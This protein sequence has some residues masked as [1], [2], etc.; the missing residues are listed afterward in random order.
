M[1]YLKKIEIVDKHIESGEWEK[2]NKLLENLAQEIPENGKVLY[3][4][5]LL[6]QQ[7]GEFDL[8]LRRYNEAMEKDPGNFFVYMNIALIKKLSGDNREEEKYLNEALE[9]AKCKEERWFAL[10]SLCTHYMNLHTYLK[11]EKFAKQIIREFED[12]YE[13]YHLY[14]EIQMRRKSYDEAISYIEEVPETMKNHPQYLADMISW[15]ERSEQ[16]EKLLDLLKNDE[17]IKKVIP[18]Y[19][20]RKRIAVSGSLGHTEE[21]IKDLF[22]MLKE[23]KDVDAAICLAFFL[24]LNGDYEQSADLAN[25]IMDEEKDNADLRFYLALFCEILSFY[26]L[27]GKKPSEKLIS[28]MQH[29]CIWCSDFVAA[30]YPELLDEILDCFEVLFEDVNE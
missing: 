3:E 23:Y 14:I 16:Y 20:L 27:S 22:D 10:S 13:G 2:A 30:T 21:A 8:A 24:F 26:Y 5:G 29:A 4:Y 18:E 9:K 19:M 28:W 11:A 25:A 17:Q 12:N 15:L 6:A 7:Q 1:E